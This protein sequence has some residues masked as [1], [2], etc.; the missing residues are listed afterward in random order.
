MGNDRFLTFFH[1]ARLG[2]LAS[3]GK[4]KNTALSEA[5]IGEGI[6]LI[7]TNASIDYLAQVAHGDNLVI[8]VTPGERAKAS[9]ELLY[10][11]KRVHDG[12]VA[13]RGS[14]KLCAFDYARQKIARL[15][16]SFLEALQ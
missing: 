11:A 2:Y 15:P 1:E 14:T 4:G 6:G 8:T 12:K 10:E 9:F 16:E 5:N 3:L 7:M 13:A